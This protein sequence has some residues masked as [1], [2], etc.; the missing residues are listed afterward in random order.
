MTAATIIM[1]ALIAFGCA[2]L[3]AGLGV[4]AYSAFRLIRLARAVGIRSSHDLERVMLQARA[5]S[6]R[7]REV[8]GRQA[9]LSERLERLS[10]SAARLSYLKDEFDR[11]VGRL[12]RF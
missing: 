7:L 3:I 9:A 10:D 4:V 5:L 11:S 12:L 1:I 2:L 6:E 8:E